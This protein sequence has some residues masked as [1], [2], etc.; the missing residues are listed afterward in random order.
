MIHEKQFNIIEHMGCHRKDF[1]PTS[2]FSILYVVNQLHAGITC[3]A[4]LSLTPFYSVYNQVIKE[5]GLIDKI[6]KLIK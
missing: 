2:Y 4:N 6:L 1:D 5:T 3:E